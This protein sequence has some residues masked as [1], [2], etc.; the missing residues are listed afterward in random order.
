MA[1]ERAAVIIGLDG[2]GHG[3]GGIAVG[4]DREIAVHRDVALR[5]VV[6]IVAG[7]SEPADVRAAR[8]RDVAVE[9][10]GR[11]GLERPFACERVGSRADIESAALI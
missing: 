10:E 7:E 2:T 1:R 8:H 6:Q 5:E 9:R 3:H 11:V 4:G